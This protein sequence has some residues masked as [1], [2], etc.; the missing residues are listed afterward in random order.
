MFVASVSHDFRTTINIIS[1]NIESIELHINLDPS[2]HD[3]ID[4]IKIAA[5]YLEVIVQDLIDYSRM[6]EKKLNIVPNILKI[7]TP[8]KDAMA[9]LKSKYNDKNIAMKIEMD[10]DP[11]LTITSDSM[12]IKQILVN[13]LSKAWKFTLE[14]EVIIK[15]F[16][17]YHSKL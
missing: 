8:L 15:V 3:Y 4:N 14:G 5:L 16:F 7:V 17:F 2:L 1:G 13:F 12:R 10:V 6:K 11:E 9:L